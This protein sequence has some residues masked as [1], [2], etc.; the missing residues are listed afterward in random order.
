LF[1]PYL[2]RPVPARIAAIEKNLSG[3]PEVKRA[4][5]E[6]DHPQISISRQCE[7]LG[8]SRSSYYYQ[9]V[10]VSEEDLLLLRLLDE[11]YTRTPF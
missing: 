11:Q 4:W 2:A 3:F 10:G 1:F 6:P 7:L 8:L 5:V 9:P